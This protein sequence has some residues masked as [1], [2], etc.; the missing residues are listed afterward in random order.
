MPMFA[1]TGRNSRGEKMA[2]RVES[3]SAQA[4]A[5]WML[6]AGITPVS[7]AERPEDERPGWL[8]MILG[9]ATLTHT[10]L[11]L[12]TRQMGV[13]IKAGV[14]MMQSLASIQK[15]TQKPRLTHLLQAL[16]DDLDRGHDLSA[17]LSRHPK[18]FNEYYVAMVRVGEG[19]GRLEEIFRRLFS[20][21]EFEQQMRQK[22]KSAVRYP[23]FVLSA[24]LA[25][26]VILNLYVIPVFAKVYSGFKVELPPL[27]NLL[28]GVSS[29]FVNYWWLLLG[30]AVIGIYLFRSWIGT[31]EG[32]YKWDKAKLRAPILGDILVKATIARFALSLS[33]ASRSGIPLMQAFT[34]VSRVVEN[35]FYEQRILQMRDGVERGDS[36][37]RVA[38]TAGIFSPLELQ[39]ISVGE[40]TGEIDEMLEQVA[41]M[42]QDDVE[43]EVDRLSDTLEPLLIGLAAVVVLILLLGVFLPLWD[44]GQVQL[45]S[46]RK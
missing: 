15:S 3:P 22:I 27:T 30:F 2:G 4:V 6:T 13:M 26:V 5:S 18:F 1:Y 41:R 10:D 45:K 28:I 14:P 35:A 31:T 32:R 40:E 37:L 23:S 8:K 11:L 43:Y 16:R 44:L 19:T 20:Q 24:I 39:M 46:I 29:F 42:Y 12:F 7:I 17:A 33:N 21:L 36:I 9:A 34:L 25:A 38:Q